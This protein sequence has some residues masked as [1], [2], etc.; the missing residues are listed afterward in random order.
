M[1]M[2]KT[3]LFFV[4]LTSMPF[5]AQWWTPQNSGVTQNLNDV[6]GITSNTVVV[7][8]N[9]GTILKTTDGGANWLQKTSGTSEN[10][11]KI[12]FVTL[13][14]GYAVGT[15]GTLLKTTNGG[16]SWASIPT[17][18]TTNLSGLSCVN[19][20]VFYI[21]GDT[22]LIEK[23]TDGGTTFSNKS[24][25]GNYSFATIQFLNDQVGYASSFTNFGSG[26]NAFI[27]T[28]NGGTAWTFVSDQISTFFFINETTGFVMSGTTFKTIDGGVTLTNMG[29]SY[30]QAS[31]LFAFNENE[32]WSVENT[33]TLC[34]CSNFC[35]R[36]STI[37]D[38]GT[39]QGAQN[40]YSDT[41]G[42]P[43]FEAIT[44][45]DATHGYVVG[46]Y[47]IIYK[48]ATGTMEDLGIDEMDKKD[49]VVIYPNPASSIITIENKSNSPLYSTLI[50][51]VNGRK[52]LEEKQGKATLDISSLVKG[53]YLVKLSSDNGNVTKKL[54]K[55]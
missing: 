5:Y 12:Q 14:L 2:K 18:I 3:I 32:V 31:D 53:V 34:G 25:A 45:A 11:T 1:A 22:G 27:K 20:N 48:N 9:G 38:T 23:T 16:E 4:I 46:D 43:P 52:V 50:Y 30:S 28:T 26:S 13:T 19:E 10:L 54:I 7:V 8:G 17:G 36:K 37:A 6:Y 55:E 42:N 39:F 33:Y 49:T 29:N 51:D 21:S 44:F 47:G 40:C 41:N 35:I 15:N 24:Y